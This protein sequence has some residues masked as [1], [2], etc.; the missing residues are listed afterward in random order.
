MKTKVGKYDPNL[1]VWREGYE[2][3]AVCECGWFTYGWPL[4]KQAKL[5]IDQHTE[6]HETGQLMPDRAEVES[7]TPGKFDSVL[8]ATDS[9][10][11]DDVWNSVS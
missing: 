4:K 9:L 11:N 1:P 3:G 2:Y 6:E 5:R 10:A 8:V 7:L